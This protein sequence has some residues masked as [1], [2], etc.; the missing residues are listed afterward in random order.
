M[1][2]LA[3]LILLLSA[4]GAAPL[5]PEKPA[6]IEDCY[7]TACGYCVRYRL[8]GKT[9]PYAPWEGQWCVSLREPEANTVD[10]SGCWAAD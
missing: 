7:P 6:D 9:V 4:C 3:L 10:C 5:A 1:N 2:R 8:A